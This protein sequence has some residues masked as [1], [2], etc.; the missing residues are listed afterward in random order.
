MV[1]YSGIDRTIHYDLVE[2]LYNVTIDPMQ[3]S[4]NDTNNTNDFFE[5]LYEE[6]YVTYNATI[7]ECKNEDYESC[8]QKHPVTKQKHSSFIILIVI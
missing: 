7:E 8:S 5:G 2:V 4:T 6:Y 3:G 1:V